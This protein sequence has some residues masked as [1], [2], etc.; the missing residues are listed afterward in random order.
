MTKIKAMRFF[1]QFG[2]NLDLAIEAHQV[3]RGEVGQEVPGVRQDV[4]EYQ[5]VKVNIVTVVN[6][7]GVEAIGKPIGSYITLESPEIKINAPEIHMH[8]SR[9]IASKLEKLIDIPSDATVLIIGLGNWQATPDA[10]GPEVISKTVAT[11]HLKDYAAEELAGGL[12]PVCALAPGVLG[13]TGIETAEIIRGVVE[14][15]KPALIIAIDALAARGVE[16]IGTSI[17]IA[18][19]G[20]N[21]GS[22]IGNHR[23]GINQDTMGVP[24]IAIGV[25]TVVNGALIAK[26]SIESL[27]HQLDIPANIGN[28]FSEDRIIQ[29]IDQ[30]LQPYSNNLV[31]TPKEI[32]SLIKN[33]SHI[34]A[35][36]IAQALHPAIDSENIY[37]YLH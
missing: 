15:V 16:R 24:V 19:T 35:A 29:A 2:V 3:V 9:V 13:T 17:Q 4:E 18:N 11:R 10:L 37:S 28:W 12:R 7:T 1:K 31:V 27:L 20:I 36:G 23:T 32:D 21:P 8:I 33:T 34:I 26:D 25:P 6:Q 22:G 30:V 14:K 5:H